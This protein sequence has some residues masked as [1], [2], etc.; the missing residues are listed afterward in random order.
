MS[1]AASSDSACSICGLVPLVPRLKGT[2]HLVAEGPAMQELLKRVARFATS[3]APVVVLG[4]TGTGKEVVARVLHANSSRA[5]QPFVA[6]NVAA[7][8]AELLE[9]ELFAE[10][11]VSEREEVVPPFAER[12]HGE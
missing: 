12:R 2:T 8:P 9:S 7:L 11:L 1:V 10:Q 4:E 3:S 6:V 5:K